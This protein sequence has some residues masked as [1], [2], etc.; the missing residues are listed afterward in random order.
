VH[1]VTDDRVL[2]L[3]DFA[4]RAAALARGDH[5]AF[6]LRSRER[7]AADRLHLARSLQRLGPL[8][9]NDRVDLAVAVRAHG[10]HLP[11]RG[12]PIATARRLLGPAGLVG[13]STHTAAEASAAHDEG[14]DYVFLGPI[15]PT[16]S[17]PGAPSLGLDAI[18]KAQPARVIAIGG[19]TPDRVPQC[20]A[21]GAWGV[22]AVTAL[23]FAEDVAA[24]ADALLL[25]LG[26]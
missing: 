9:I 15:W 8:I 3:P 2:S 14:A 23:W 26:Q 7:S 16:P 17:H 12:V 22:A 11:A 1:A 21:A 24:A 25:S 5:V 18:T 13:R 20:L 10:V 4:T 6:H 19:I